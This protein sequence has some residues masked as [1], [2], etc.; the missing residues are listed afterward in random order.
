[1]TQLGRYMVLELFMLVVVSLA[2]ARSGNPGQPG[3]EGKSVAPVF[4][5][6]DAARLLADLQQAL[7]GNDQRR[8]LK[9][10]DARRMPNYASFQDQVTEFFGKY[11]SFRMRYHITQIFAEADLGI[12]LTELELEA[13]PAGA[14]VP[15]RRNIQ[16]RLVT[17]WD[18]KRWKVVDWRPRSVLS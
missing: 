10:F 9:L 17:A 18:G 4:S 2:G 1:M 7:E 14:S 16:L 13:T 12:V 11:E 6:A 15:D 3:K 8:F 5:D